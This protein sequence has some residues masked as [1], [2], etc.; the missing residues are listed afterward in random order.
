MRTPESFNQAG[1]RLPGY[2]GIVITEVDLSRVSGRLP[3]VESVIAP[4]GYLHAGTVVALADTL[5]G[6]GCVANLPPEAV[7]FTTIELK[8]NHLGTAGHDSRR[9]DARA[10]RQDDPGGMRSSPI[11]TGRTL[12]VFQLHP[13]DSLQQGE[14]QH[15]VASP[16]S[17]LKSRDVRRPHAPR[18]RV[19]ISIL[20]NTWISRHRRR[21]AFSPFTFI[22]CSRRGWEKHSGAYLR[23]RNLVAATP[24]GATRNRDTANSI[25]RRFRFRGSVDVIQRALRLFAL[26][27]AAAIGVPPGKRQPRSGEQQGRSTPQE[28][29]RKQWWP[30]GISAEQPCKSKS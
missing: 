21:R 9:R 10:S 18:R 15:R 29:I 27:A 12:A 4:N 25:G 30:N 8:S 5:A 24:A 28:K 7:G 19:S 6:Y 16:M 26:L 22:G 23:R 11:E 13:D 2:L 20:I 3:V 1:A 17:T 14:Q